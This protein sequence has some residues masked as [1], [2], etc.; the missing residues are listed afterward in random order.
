MIEVKINSLDEALQK[1]YPPWVRRTIEIPDISIYRA[2][3]DSVEKNKDNIAIDFMGN[4][5]TYS[6]L[7]EKIDSIS[8]R[9]GELGI[10]K[11][12]RIA[13]MLPNIPQYITY[14]FAIVKLGAIIVK[15]GFSDIVRFTYDVFVAYI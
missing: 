11:G 12:D 13:V 8:V 9:L 4:K 1:S 15:W 10:T 7:K 6:S 3:S 5:I 2:F 14:F